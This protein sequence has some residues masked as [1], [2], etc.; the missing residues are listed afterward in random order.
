M[1]H[2]QAEL[3]YR[4]LSVLSEDDPRYNETMSALVPLEYRFSPE[5]NYD[6]QLYFGPNKYK[7]T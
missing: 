3:S 7:I 6:M 2:F 1:M 4:P 5:A